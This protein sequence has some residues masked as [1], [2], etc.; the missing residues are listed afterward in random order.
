MRL[1][2]YGN[3]SASRQ[4]ERVDEFANE[5]P[6]VVAVPAAYYNGLLVASSRTREDHP[7]VYHSRESLIYSP[8]PEEWTEKK[9]QD[10]D[11]NEH[12]TLLNSSHICNGTFIM[13][14][15]L[16]I[17]IMTIGIDGS[18]YMFASTTF[19]DAICN[20]VS[21]PRQWR[22]VVRTMCV[23][24]IDVDVWRERKSGNQCFS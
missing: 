9:N 8:M 17:M 2:S 3:V 4:W 21:C 16:I 1:A 20:T 10:Q 7:L 24:A 19:N 5:K 13:R 22:V 12:V 11:L 14:F 18:E 23:A 15:V 6:V